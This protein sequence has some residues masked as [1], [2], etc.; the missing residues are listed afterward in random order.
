MLKKDLKWKDRNILYN[1]FNTLIFITLGKISIK[2]INFSFYLYIFIL[3]KKILLNLYPF[4]INIKKILLFIVNN[5]ILK[6]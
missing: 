4:Y 6:Q 1:S 5:I 3:V 2:T